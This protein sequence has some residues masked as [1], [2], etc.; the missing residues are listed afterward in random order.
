VLADDEGSSKQTYEAPNL[1][2]NCGR[3]LCHHSK[4]QCVVD[5]DRKADGSSSRFEVLVWQLVSGAGSAGQEYAC[6]VLDVR[7][8]AKKALC[9]CLA[10]RAPF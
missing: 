7:G 5:E 9:H 6:C 4:G 8:A 2:S 3:N 10:V 1:C